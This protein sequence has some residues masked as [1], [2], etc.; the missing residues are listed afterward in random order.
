[1]KFSR[2]SSRGKLV[3]YSVYRADGT[4]EARG[5]MSG[6]VPIE[7]PAED[8]SYYHLAVAAG[9][10][11]F[12]IEVSGAAWAVDAGLDDQG[13][14]FLGAAPDVYFEVPPGIESF[15]LSLQA[16]PPGETAV[17]TL[18]APD[19]NRVAEFDCT[20]LSVDRQS[21]PVTRANAG[22]WKVQIDK[23][24]TGVIDDV[25]LKP[26]KQ[27]KAHFSLDPAQALS[28]EPAK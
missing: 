20:K 13:L 6:E 5:L 10:A 2:I 11:S 1:V 27:L 7:L 9:S 3:T 12:M 22:W 21:I 24:P 26:G 17:A 14:H 4:E 23:A 15:H 8:V 19:G 18:H 25:W 16:T 28:I